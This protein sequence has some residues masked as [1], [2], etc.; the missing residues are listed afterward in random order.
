MTAMGRVVVRKTMS[1]KTIITSIVLVA[2][3]AGTYVAF[4][5]FGGKTRTIDQ[6]LQKYEF[7]ELDPP[8]TLAPPGTLVVVQVARSI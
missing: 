1:R 5:V 6:I 8:S 3:A 4:M 2:T 7:T